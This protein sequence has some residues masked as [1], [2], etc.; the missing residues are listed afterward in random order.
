MQFQV[1]TGAA[2]QQRTACAIVPVFSGGDLPSAA[3]SLDKAGGGLISRAIR[4]KDI[5]GELGDMLL[6]THTGE[7]PCQRILLVGSRGRIEI[8][9][10]GNI[11][12][13]RGNGLCGGIHCVACHFDRATHAPVIGSAPTSAVE[14]VFTRLLED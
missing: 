1:K 11:K 8:E 12:W 10:Q 14:R 4:N 3:S 6:L 5:K 13:R 7:L 9:I 2:S